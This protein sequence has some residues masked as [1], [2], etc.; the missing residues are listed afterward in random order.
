[1]SKI[2]Q[3]VRHL[4]VVAIATLAA[5]LGWAEAG[6]VIS[7][8]VAQQDANL[9]AA[10]TTLASDVQIPAAAWVGIG[11]PSGGTKSV[12]A[13]K[14]YNVVSKQ[15]T[16]ASANYT[17]KAYSEAG[18]NWCFFNNGSDAANVKALSKSTDYGYLKEWASNRDRSC[19]PG[20]LEISNVPFAK[21]TVYIYFQGATAG[22]SVGGR[23]K[24]L[25]P[26][27]AAVTQLD[28]FRVDSGNAVY[29]GDKLWK[30]GSDGSLVDTGATYSGNFSNSNGPA[31]N[32]TDCWGARNNV[33]AA[34]GTNV[35]KIPL[36]SGTFKISYWARASG[37]AAIQI[38]ED[39]PYEATIDAQTTAWTDLVWGGGRSWQNGSDVKLTVA[40]DS[41]LTLGSA[42]TCGAIK[43]VGSANLTI[44]DPQNLSYTKIDLS[45]Y[46]G[47]LTLNVTT[48]MTA[49]AI[50][51]GT[52]VK[53]GTAGLGVN[54]KESL[55]ALDG[56]TL[57][58]N[59]GT[60]TL[61]STD[62]GSV[63]KN[64]TFVLNG[65][66]LTNYGWPTL[67]GTTTFVNEADASVFM[68][69]YLGGGSAIVKQ[70]AGK[71]SCQSGSDG[72]FASIKV[73]GGIL[74]FAGNP[75]TATTLIAGAGAIEIPSGKTLTV[76][77]LSGTG[78]VNVTG[79]GTLKVQN[80]SAFAGSLNL[81][82]SVALDLGTMRPSFAITT[83]DTASVK[84]QT[85]A[86]DDGSVT[87]K[88]TVENV[89]VI[90]AD[91]NPLTDGV[92]KGTSE[93]VTTITFPIVVSGK[94][95]WIAY[96]FNG[97][98]NSTGTDTGSLSRDQDNY[99]YR[100]GDDST[101]DFRPASN[102]EGY[103]ALYA[104]SHPW[105]NITYKDSFTCAMYG[106]LPQADEAGL[107]V[108]GST[109]SA[110]QG[111]IGLMTGS[112][113]NNTVLLV[114]STGSQNN[115]T[116]YET[117]AEM[118]V[119]NPFTTPH[120][121]I[122]S[123]TGRTI[124]V[125]LDGIL[126]TT[127]ESTTDFVI[128]PG[129]QICSVHGGSYTTGVNRFAPPSR[130]A[131]Q[132]Q[133][134]YKECVIDSLRLYDGVLGEKAI[135]ALKTEFPYVSPNG[136]YSRSVADASTWSETDAWTKA[137]DNTAS[138]LPAVGSAL[139]LSATTAT[140]AIT[141]GLDSTTTYEAITFGGSEGSTITVKKGT[142]LVANA[143]Q[144]VVSVPVT[145]EEGAMTVS[146][147][148]TV[149]TG[150]G[151]L[152]FDYSALD[153]NSYKADAFIQLTGMMDVAA[154][155]V[156]CTLPEASTYSDRTVTF[157]YDTASKTYRITI[158][159]N[160]IT[161]TIPSFE[162]TTVAVTVNGAAV[163]V[164]NDQITAK[165]G[166]TV[167]V[168]YT[169]VTGQ[170][171]TAETTSQTIEDLA[172]NS[173][174][175]F[176]EMPT[177][178]NVYTVAVM[179]KEH[180]ITTVTIGS[181]EPAVVTEASVQVSHGESYRA[182]YTAE[183]GYYLTGTTEN[184]H[185]DQVTENKGDYTLNFDVHKIVATING[186]P[187]DSVQAAIEA[188]IDGQTLADITVVDKTAGLPE[189]YE[190]YL[191]DEDGKI[192]LAAVIFTFG[193][194][195]EGAIVRCF[196]DGEFAPESAVIGNTLT[197][198]VGSKISIIYYPDT[199]NYY[200]GSPL[201]LIDYP[202]TAGMTE[203]Q[204][205]APTA[206][207]L[208]LKKAVAGV[209]AGDP[210]NPTATLHATVAEAIEVDSVYGIT[211][212]ENVT[213]NITIPEG[214]SIVLMGEK[215]ITPA[216]AT[217]YTIDVQGSLV[218]DGP[219]IEG[220]QGI[221][222][223]GPSAIRVG[224]ADADTAAGRTASLTVKSGAVNYGLNPI[225][226]DSG[227]VV[228]IQG[229]SFTK[230]HAV[231]GTHIVL[232]YGALTISGGT[233]TATTASAN[234]IT[235]SAPGTV[236]ITGG[237]YYGATSNI[238][239]AMPEGYHLIY[240]TGSKVTVSNEATDY[241]FF[242]TSAKTFYCA[243]MDAVIEKEGFFQTSAGVYITRASGFQNNASLTMIS[244]FTYTISLG[245]AID[246]SRTNFTLDLGGHTMTLSS[247]TVAQLPM[248]VSGTVTLK[249]GTI[250]CASCEIKKATASL[251]VYDGV[252]IPTPTTSVDGMKVVADTATVSGATVYTLA[253]DGP[254][255]IEDVT[256]DNVAD[257]IPE[258]VTTAE[259]GAL[260]DWI[261]NTSGIESV[262]GLKDI[263]VN[264]LIFNC[265]NESAPA[266]AKAEADAADAI[267]KDLASKVD[268]TKLTTGELNE[269]TL[270]KLSKEYP[271]AK[272]E[273]KDVT[274]DV[275]G[276]GATNTHLFKLSIELK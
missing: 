192:V 4:A 253:K 141:V 77:S 104:G 88:G 35:A 149:I 90:G 143:G 62:A 22:I 250:N 125:Y 56:T 165:A 223:N 162:N 212:L 34:L 231:K 151:S 132:N 28:P 66:T 247:K 17:V 20:T 70:G 122:F 262:E 96:E 87:L 189:G 242:Y 76:G 260:V 268:L 245:S 2:T 161:L 140:S 264:A 241:P 110:P 99:Q 146:G 156:S 117:M 52:V 197:A 107:L 178:I 172:S 93:G 79:A 171:L 206:E 19:I 124:K 251:T 103:D 221:T 7:I 67:Q 155:K 98:L 217:T 209:L 199:A 228:D 48:A 249:N 130:D 83:A 118:S 128:G 14:M 226:G 243:D 150:A 163:T 186:T 72:A 257:V 95:C 68:T 232:T 152:S 224:W 236:T 91:G 38:V 27:T 101:S 207:E 205:E 237:T 113:E 208:K 164:E 21:Y 126:W 31:I 102:G 185:Y 211:L 108:F 158:T 213:E 174:V 173:S 187:Y 127:Y 220:V 89:T 43:V 100:Y 11:Q 142:G 263:N 267:L 160:D 57:K 51:G 65:G 159:M 134:I 246:F 275:A 269:E 204:L 248:T 261:K 49:G 183:E 188:L 120:L 119:P 59:A 274:T 235:A 157:G 44:A 80:D 154:D 272:I 202:I 133:A 200:L 106:T 36:C 239:K 37:P 61:N 254:A 218:I 55:A 179:H 190:D 81:S 10:Q 238:V 259:T 176:T 41:T 39:L 12:S 215:S 255:V 45:D 29:V 40:A 60:V 153:V 227:S 9:T 58:I 271:M 234:T 92:T 8:R 23:G 230:D 129:F 32:A 30:V 203:T 201:G 116:K 86:L 276:E 252:T 121:Y 240:Q 148:P 144:T 5:Q 180:V 6:D 71:L 84:I 181:N 270:A 229:G 168:T 85:S 97:N 47:E 18:G 195:P 191:I 123:K 225:K 135:A 64:A 112:V 258:T 105:R 139:T 137:G 147:G 219:T 265:S 3:Y 182:D 244:D 256:T 131:A 94:A 16:T 210:L 145:I 73:E 222:D 167:V 33:S 115:A 42:I 50:V 198:P 109:T 54:T 266:T 82:G 194:A 26:S 114:R 53:A 24:A 69:K 177:E 184:Y 15:E 166:S 138:E 111:L 1:M 74:A 13:N 136:S 216:D 233:F 273:L 75:A 214:K 175:S 170:H 78:D 46:T 63:S 196:I 25:E 169:A 193:A